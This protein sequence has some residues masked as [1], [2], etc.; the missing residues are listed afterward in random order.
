MMLVLK[1]KRP[2]YVA[3]GALVIG[4]STKATP[5]QAGEKSSLQRGEEQKRKR[6]PV[7]VLTVGI[8]GIGGP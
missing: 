7:E 1:G 4:S 6:H 8:C 2:V 3:Q 5:G